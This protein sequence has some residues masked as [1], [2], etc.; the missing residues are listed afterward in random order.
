MVLRESARR[1]GAIVAVEF[2]HIDKWIM[3]NLKTKSDCPTSEETN[4][5]DEAAKR[6]EQ[7]LWELEAQWQRK[8]AALRAA[9]CTEITE[10]PEE[11]TIEEDVAAMQKAF[12]HD[13]SPED[14][15]A[16]TK[17]I[18]R[19]KVS[20][21]QAFI[22]SVMDDYEPD[23]IFML[24]QFK[25]DR[26]VDYWRQFAHC[27]KEDRCCSQM[28]LA[29]RLLQI[30]LNKGAEDRYHT[31]LTQYVN[32]RN[33]ARFAVRYCTQTYSFLLGKRQEV[34]YRKA[35]CLFFKLLQENILNW[36]D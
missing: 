35:Y 8:M 24:L 11:T 21:W 26:M 36:W 28:E 23:E 9:P 14:W 12:R 10:N 5:A 27:A 20:K 2:L 17:L 32:R 1:A 16:F 4:R 30:I 19:Q 7:R 3:E 6:E 22:G 29:S 34:R 15:S 25:I 31:K 33:E 13:M 18:H